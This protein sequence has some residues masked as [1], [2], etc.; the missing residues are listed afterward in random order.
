MSDF[1]GSV[2][3]P[4]R[5]ILEILLAFSNVVCYYSSGY[6]KSDDRVVCYR[7]HFFS[8]CGMVGAAWVWYR[9]F[10]RELLSER[11]VGTAV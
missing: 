11:K 8:E 1:T 4:R 3:T 6:G 9:A 2:Q 7:K 5:F 10:S